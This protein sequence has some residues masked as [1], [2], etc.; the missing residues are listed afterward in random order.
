MLMRQERL[1]GYVLHQRPYQEKKAI[2]Q[3]FSQEHGVVHGIASK[4][5]PAFVP[6]ELFAS[7]KGSLKSFSKFALVDA[8]AAAMA[9]PVS[10]QVQY[11]LLYLNEIL[12]KLLEAQNSCVALWLAYQA[13]VQQLLALGVVSMQDV[14]KM[15]QIRLLLRSFERVLFAE[16]GVDVALDMDCDGKAI[17]AAIYYC[18]VPESGFV[19]ADVQ[20]AGDGR[21]F[22]EDL[23]TMALRTEAAYLEKLSVFGQLQKQMIDYVLGYRPLNS[24]KLWQ[25]SYRYQRL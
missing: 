22:G 13:H 7:G 4:G 14:D 23:L 21:F 12:Y 6:L 24:R 20:R 1:T 10:G 15:R 9:A 11:A 17:D 5:M 2:Y 16:L 8:Q 18:F 3:L 25:Q 19:P